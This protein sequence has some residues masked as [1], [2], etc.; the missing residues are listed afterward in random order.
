MLEDGSYVVSF[1]ADEIALGNVE[2]PQVQQISSNSTNQLMNSAKNDACRSTSKNNTM[3]FQSFTDFTKKLDE[4]FEEIIISGI[5][6][7]LRKSIQEKLSSG[8]E[9]IPKENNAVIN[10]IIDAVNEQYG[11]NR[12]PMKLCDM[13]AELLKLKYPIT[14]RIN[15]TVMTAVGELA[16]SK[17]KGEGGHGNLAQRTS[18]NFYN[19]VVR[20]NL[21][22]PAA[23]TDDERDASEPKK[24]RLKGGYCLSS[25]R[26]NDDFGAS[27]DEKEEAKRAYFQI[28][29]SDKIDEKKGL[30]LSSTRFVQK[31]F[32]ESEPNKAVVDL[33]IM[34]AEGPC[35]LDCW[36]EWL[37]GG[38]ERGCLITMANEHLAKVITIMEKFIMMKKGDEVE[39]VMENIKSNAVTKTGKIVRYQVGLISTH[40]NG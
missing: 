12:P 37:V 29:H 38:T 18:D 9:L 32:R 35:L 24:K 26:W 16:V 3:K 14:Y 6:S 28:Q 19:R 8:K 5:Q 10:S 40:I 22:R 7:G 30:L 36:F 2:L 15:K 11:A 13:L 25:E 17:K 27:K 21:K 34:W 33:K 1:S 20:P 23:T 31:Q 4:K 39:A